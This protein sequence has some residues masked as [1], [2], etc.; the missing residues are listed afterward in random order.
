[1]RNATIHRHSE[2]SEESAFQQIAVR[3]ESRKV[4]REV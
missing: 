1:M 4:L 2:R 3:V